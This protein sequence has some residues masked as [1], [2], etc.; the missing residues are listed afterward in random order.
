MQVRRPAIE[1][2]VNMSWSAVIARAV[3]IE[4]KATVRSAVDGSVTVTVTKTVEAI[5]SVTVSVQAPTVTTVKTIEASK[6]VT[7]SVQS[8]VKSYLY[9][10][11][12]ATGTVQDKPFVRM[13]YSVSTIVTGP[14][15]YLGL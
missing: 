6:N 2:D 8:S 9:A 15:P 11:V 1:Y 4:V 10:K 7:V 3:P 5:R 14:R 12:S 13:L